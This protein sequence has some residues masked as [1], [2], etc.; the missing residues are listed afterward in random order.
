MRG[1]TDG[2]TKFLKWIFKQNETA[3]IKTLQALSIIFFYDIRFCVCSVLNNSLTFDVFCC[4]CFVTVFTIFVT[5]A[6]SFRAYLGS[7]SRRASR[8]S[9]SIHTGRNRY[10][11]RLFAHLARNHSGLTH[12]RAASK[13]ATDPGYVFS[14]ERPG[15]PCLFVCFFKTAAVFLARFRGGSPSV[16]ARRSWPAKSSGRKFARYI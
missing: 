14:L 8:T 11:N 13:G 16:F 1:R 5:S 3:I 2:R 4:C 10:L 15:V 12:G 6:R 7:D 9:G